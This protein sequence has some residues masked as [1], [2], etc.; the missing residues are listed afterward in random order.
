MKIFRT[1]LLTTEAR[2]PSLVNPF[3]SHAE[4]DLSVQVLFQLILII[5]KPKK[6]IFI[7]WLKSA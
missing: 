6:G 4:L 2:C 1:K 3:L 7:P 5:P